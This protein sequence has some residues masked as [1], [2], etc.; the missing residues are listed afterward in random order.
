MIILIAMVLGL[1][2]GYYSEQA[3]Y[4]TEMMAKAF[5]TLLQM[6]ALPYISLSLIAGIG[7]LQPTQGLTLMRKGLL[8]L[9]PLMALCL[10]VV[11]TGPAAFPDWPNASF[12]SANTVKEIEQVGLVDLFIPSN[13]FTAFADALI[14]AIVL[15]SI[16]M[17]VGLIG[18]KDNKA[19]LHYLGQLQSAIANINSLTMKLAPLAVFCIAQSALATLQTQQIDGLFVYI[20]TA[21]AIMFLLSF[22]VLPAIV[23]ILTP[24]YYREVILVCREGLITAFATG[25]FFV[26]IP[27]VAEKIKAL[28]QLRHCTHQSADQLPNIIVPISFSLPVG[29]KLFA[30]LFI[31][32]SAW[33]SGERIIIGDYQ[34][35]VLQGL[36]QLF[37]SIFLAVPVLLDIFNISG[38]M[39][40]LFVVSENLIVSRLGAVFSV[41]FA[42]S[43]S[44]LIATTVSGQL[45]MVWKRLL[46]FLVFVPPVALG[47]LLMIS[48]VFDSISHQYQGYEKFINRDFTTYKVKST[49]LKEPAANSLN[50]TL[51]GNTLTRIAM[52]GKLRVGYF[53]DD[54]PYAFHNKQ[55]KLVGF[56][57]EIMNMLAADLGVDVEFVRIY[58]KDTAPLLESG[59]IDIASGMPL[60]PEN[61]KDYTLTAPYSEQ[62]IA[63]LVK[64]DRR[65]SF[66]TWQKIVDQKDDLL[67]G[68]PE[69]FFYRNG[70][71]THLGHNNIWELASPRL[72]FNEKYQNIDALL[73]GAASASAW[74]LLYPNYS[75]V[76]PKPALPPLLLAFPI[77]RHDYDFEH[78]MTNWIASKKRNRSIDQL[79]DYWI[80]GQ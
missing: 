26:V 37:G 2:A 66:N 10:L 80:K 46:R 7:G 21:A 28:L 45:R 40:D 70:I 33:F 76:V 52:R 53:R 17:G 61:M 49:Y 13:P 11:L 57:I 50:Q 23:A 64:T 27:L 60:I 19:T 9:I 36:P 55:G 69:A 14:P 67:L 51:T 54:L 3:F 59:Y 62:T 43:L 39:F 25:S 63:L 75:V 32:F 68:V 20:T 15:F 79:F 24:F 1:L 65:S 34:N 16:L 29:G 44:L 5:V 78:F 48:E 4:G 6:T 22:I 47:I 58:R 74:S 35:L 73:F 38:S 30:L 41:M 56:D 8:V 72:L 71:R 42:V 12:Y 18:V 31:I 77:T